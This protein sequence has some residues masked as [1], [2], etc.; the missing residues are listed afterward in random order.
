[1]VQVTKL[2]LAP[3]HSQVVSTLPLCVLE[4]YVVLLQQD[5]LVPQESNL[6]LQHILSS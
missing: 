4:L 1:M 6:P 2:M 5:V 3:F